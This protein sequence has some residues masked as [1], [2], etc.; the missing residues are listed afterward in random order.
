[1]GILIF[2]IICA[3]VCGFMGAWTGAGG[4]KDWRRL[5]VPAV[6]AVFGCFV[7]W[8][9]KPL[10]LM[11]RFFALQAGYGMPDET[12]GHEDE[13]SQIGAFWLDNL[14]NMD[15][16]RIM[17]RV[18]IGILEASSFMII[19]MMVNT[20]GAWSLYAWAA[21]AVVGINV[22][23]GAHVKGEGQIVI[24]GKKLLVEEI[25]IHGLNTLVIMGFIVL[26]R[27]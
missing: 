18:T 13:G 17:T 25:A 26:C 2:L 3:I 14:G 19:P 24:F 4:R 6:A 8:S 22:L 1:M 9:L 20:V 11:G 23:F 15:L 27:K 16:A 12:P 7:L 21:L 10:L 5:V